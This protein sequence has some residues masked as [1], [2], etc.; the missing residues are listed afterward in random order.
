MAKRNFFI[1]NRRKEKIYEKYK[2]R[3]NKNA[4]K[5]KKAN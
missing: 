3:K 2:N 4:K 1:K 5:K